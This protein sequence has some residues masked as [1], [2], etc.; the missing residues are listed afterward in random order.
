MMLNRA[1][2]SGENGGIDLVKPA[3][4]LVVRGGFIGEIWI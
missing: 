2:G 4:I 1:L 3:V